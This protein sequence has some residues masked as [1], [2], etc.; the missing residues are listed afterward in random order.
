MNRVYAAI[1]TQIT[2]YFLATAV[3]VKRNDLLGHAPATARPDLKIAGH[4]WPDL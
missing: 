3:A 2:N 4:F 1:I